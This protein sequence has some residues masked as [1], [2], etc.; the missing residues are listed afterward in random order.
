MNGGDV[1]NILQSRYNKIQISDYVV[2][3]FRNK[4]IQK[5]ELKE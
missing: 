4:I 2:P 1:G 3:K 5:H